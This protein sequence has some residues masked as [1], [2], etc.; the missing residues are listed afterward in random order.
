MSNLDNAKAIIEQLSLTEKE[1][2][3]IWL[4][5]NLWAAMPKQSIV[6][7]FKQLRD[8]SSGVWDELDDDQVKE[9]LGRD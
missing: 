8:I 1:E 5:E 6:E 7:T 2:L 4:Q 3:S 9:M